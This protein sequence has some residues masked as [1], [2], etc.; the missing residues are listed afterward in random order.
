M[1]SSFIINQTGENTEG[2]DDEE[3]RVLSTDR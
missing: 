2:Y 3:H 1:G